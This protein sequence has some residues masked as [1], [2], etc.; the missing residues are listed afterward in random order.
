MSFASLKNAATDCKMKK[1]GNGE[2]ALFVKSLQV[3]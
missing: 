1:M 3:L 2:S